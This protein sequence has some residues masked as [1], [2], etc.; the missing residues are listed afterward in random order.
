MMTVA[1]SLQFPYPG[2]QEYPHSNVSGPP[3]QVGP[4]AVLFTPGQN[5]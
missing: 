2:E 5:V 4:P 3:V 1:P